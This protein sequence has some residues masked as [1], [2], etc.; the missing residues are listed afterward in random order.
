LVKVSRCRDDTNSTISVDYATADVTATN[1]LDYAATNGMLSFA[2]GEM[3]KA[4]SPGH[5]PRGSDR[6]RSAGTSGTV[7]CSGLPAQDSQAGAGNGAGAL[8]F[9][10][11][12]LGSVMPDL[13]RYLGHKTEMPAGRLNCS[14]GRHFRF[15]WCVSLR[16]HELL[17]FRTLVKWRR[18][19]VKISFA[20]CYE[21]SVAGTLGRISSSQ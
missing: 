17:R 1:G 4:V 2:P 19:P 12:R 20:A 13:I 16:A 7:P 6:S 11:E 21:W 5:G 14:S 8:S 18:R 10:V 9:Q 15:T 3:G